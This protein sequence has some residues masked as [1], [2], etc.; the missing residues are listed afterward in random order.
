MYNK[1]K[2]LVI[3][4]KNKKELTT[5][6]FIGYDSYDNFGLGCQRLWFILHLIIFF[7]YCYLFFKILVIC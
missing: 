1:N 6:Y 4:K 3:F 7:L 2:Y 5:N